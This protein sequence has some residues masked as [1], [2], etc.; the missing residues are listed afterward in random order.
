MDKIFYYCETN[1]KVDFLCKMIYNNCIGDG[2]PFTQIVSNRAILLL[3]A[4]S[5][6]TIKLNK[7][8]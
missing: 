8:H 1:G 4:K 6:Q 7:A 2:T 5:G 3:K